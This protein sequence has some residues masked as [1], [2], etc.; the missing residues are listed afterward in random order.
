MGGVAVVVGGVCGDGG[1]LIELRL[2]RVAG[3]IPSF[4]LWWDG[5]EV[6][7]V[8]WESFKAA[9]FTP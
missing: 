8:W 4:F 5:V 2:K 7:K 1:I 6:W 9:P 3:A